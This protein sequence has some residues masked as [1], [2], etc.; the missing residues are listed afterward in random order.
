[1][2]ALQVLQALAV[3]S[4]NSIHMIDC[5]KRVGNFVLCP[6]FIAQT[7]YPT[8]PV[9]F[10]FN[11]S[12]NVLV[13]PLNQIPNLSLGNPKLSANPIEVKGQDSIAGLLSIKSAMLFIHLELGPIVFTRYQR[14]LI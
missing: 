11:N 13:S 4:K 8:S 14:M 5:N 3:E 2:L 6:F 1:M 10:S 7:M 9:G 12:S